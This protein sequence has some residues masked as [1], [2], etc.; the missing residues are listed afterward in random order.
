MGMGG[1]CGSPAPDGG[2]VAAA[3]VVGGLAAAAAAAVGGGGGAG[4]PGNMHGRLTPNHTVTQT[5]QTTATSW[6]PYSKN[7]FG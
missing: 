2:A 1:H 7:G 6:Y 4:G 3:G 5:I